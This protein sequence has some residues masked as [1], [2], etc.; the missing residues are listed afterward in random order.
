[1]TSKLTREE[2]LNI[3]ETGHAQCGDV[4]IIALQ[5]LD[6]MDGQLATVMSDDYVIVPKELTPDKIRSIQLNSDVGR[7]IT[8]NWCDAYAAL[9]ELWTVAIAPIAK[10]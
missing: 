9:Q 5:L 2:L 4:S 1:M 10:K 3:I 8:T 6:I 7:Y